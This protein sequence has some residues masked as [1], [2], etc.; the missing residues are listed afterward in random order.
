MTI[1]LYWGSGSPFAWRAMLALEA[2]KILYTSRLIEF[3]KGE[4][5]APAYLV[6]N[7]RGQVPVLKD[8]GVVLYESLAILNYLEKKQPEPALLGRTPT[9]TGRIWRAIS[10]CL[11]Y[12]EQPAF[13][14]IGPLFFGGAAEKAN[15]IKTAAE[16]IHKEFAA[17]DQALSRQSWV[18]GDAMSAAD[19]WVYPVL[20]LL[21][22]A[23]GKA[24]AKPLELG[25]LPPE[26]RYPAIETWR[27]RVEALPGYERTYPPHWKQAA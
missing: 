6:M 23:A 11:Y 17:L 19:L 5:K 26:A 7:P 3:S 15:E 13:K 1:E 20:M 22:R 9:E 27:K 25:L 8:D 4:H 16:S 14:I 10:E 24:E 21:L 18:A 12:V 2:K